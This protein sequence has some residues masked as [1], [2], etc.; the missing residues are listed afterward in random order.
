MMACQDLKDHQD[1][2]RYWIV[3]A[4]PETA[5]RD[6]T[7]SIRAARLGRMMP[8]VMVVSCSSARSFILESEDEQDASSQKR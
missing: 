6:G 5:T 3:V 7:V 2:Y 1:W 8:A 4:M